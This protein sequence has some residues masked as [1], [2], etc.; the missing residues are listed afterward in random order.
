[1]SPTVSELRNRIRE[2]AGR[3][4]REVD[5]QFTKEE[6]AAIASAVDADVDDHRPGKRETRAAIRR[7]T[8]IAGDGDA[9]GA[10]FRKDDLRAIA[11]ALPDP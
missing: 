5:A 7:A 4:R 9:S 1:M 3:F 11:D 10:S 6:L 8:G 2:G